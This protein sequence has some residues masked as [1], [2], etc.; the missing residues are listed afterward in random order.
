MIG[1]F[2][3]VL[4]TIQLNSQ[5]YSLNQKESSI[6]ISG[7]SSL[8]DWDVV[9]KDFAGTL[10]LKDEGNLEIYF[11][12]VNVV[13]ES[14]KSGK[15]GMDKNTYKAL[16]TDNYKDIKFKLKVVKSCNKINAST[17]EVK[18]LG[19]LNITGVTK[20][21]PVD[22]LFI[23]KEK[24]INVTGSCTFKMTDFNVEPPTALFGTIKTGDEIT[25]K[26][27]TFFL[28]K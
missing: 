20:T 25:I 9:A 26:F 24:D 28:K 23:V 3:T 15:K 18:L 17:F 14:L 4:F 22:A 8:H 1:L 16:K 12:S 27:N 7:T 6:T 21:I 10:K 19:E 5:N 2:C 13:S 11:L